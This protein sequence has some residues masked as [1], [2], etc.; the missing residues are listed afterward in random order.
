[1]QRLLI[2]SDVL[3]ELWRGKP[4]AINTIQQYAKTNILA[5]SVVTWYELIVGCRDKK[6]L[7]S[8]T[9]FLEDFE[10]IL[11]HEQISKGT[12][13]LL[14]QYRL[15]HGLLTSDALIASTAIT[16]GLE[17]LSRNQKDFRFIQNLNLLPY[18]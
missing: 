11:I 2:D 14:T 4:E 3:I 1:M 8:V 13:T 10:L 12:Q 16:H 15:S 9:H 17:L 7:L 5:I 18:P 6:E